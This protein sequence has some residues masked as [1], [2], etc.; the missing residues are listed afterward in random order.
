MKKL[1]Y[2]F[3]VFL[4]ALM[5]VSSAYAVQSDMKSD[6]YNSYVSLGDFT[7]GKTDFSNA[8]YYGNLVYVNIHS[9]DYSPIP[10]TQEYMDLRGTF[11]INSGD[12]IFLQ[13]GKVVSAKGG[14]TFELV[15]DMSLGDSGLTYTLGS[16]DRQVKLISGPDG[17]LNSADVS[18]T[19]P[20]DYS[21]LSQSNVTLRTFKT[22]AEQLTS[23]IPYV[24]LTLSNDNSTVT[25]FKWRLV[26]SPDLTT[27]ISFD[28]P[29]SVRLRSY[30]ESIASQNFDWQTIDQ[31]VTA[32]GDC[33]LTAEITSDDIYYLRV[34]IMDVPENK[35]YEWRFYNPDSERF[36]LWVNHRAVISLDKDNKPHYETA[37]FSLL[38]F[39]TNVERHPVESDDFATTGTITLPASSRNYTVVE[40]R[41]PDKVLETV[42]AGTSKTFP[43]TPYKDVVSFNRSNI[44]H[45]I[46]SGDVDIEF[47]G[48]A[49]TG[50]NNRNVSLYLPTLGWNNDTIT[51]PA[52]KSVRQQ[53]QTYVPY[54]ELTSSDG[55]LKGV[56]T[57]FVLSSDVTKTGKPADFYDFRI[58]VCDKDNNEIDGTSWTQE[59]SDDVTFS[60]DISASEVDSIRVRYRREEPYHLWTAHQWNFYVTGV[61]S[62]DFVPV[63]PDSSDTDS[64][65][66][67][68]SS[69]TVTPG[70][71]GG[72]CMVGS[73]ALALAALGMFITLKRSK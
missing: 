9:A 29:M 11:T 31:G 32:S 3:L 50:F 18:W 55:K 34:R 33:T 12:Y 28:R 30:H 53:L 24:E 5:V 44:D 38:H 35:E 71:S 42:S 70:S 37:K 16:G 69:S 22:T 36:F 56:K 66:S 48:G 43:L 6:V 8:R 62:E 40:Y 49:E 68:G 39:D 52:F 54:I 64:D 58:L 4:F 59:I 20:G 17:G 15:P 19:F 57:S 72:G 7:D 67:G 63:T 14:T 25:G 27:A 13:N 10:A 60:P 23:C 41:N 65:D 21:Y 51:L 61:A 73:S 47:G 26:K 2:T 46:Y 1:F 45:I